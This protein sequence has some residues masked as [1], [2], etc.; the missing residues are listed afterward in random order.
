MFRHHIITNLGN[1]RLCKLYVSLGAYTNNE[2]CISNNW[3]SWSI[4]QA[5]EITRV[6]AAGPYLASRDALP[7]E[8]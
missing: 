4:A 5:Q 1:A 7:Q 6:M 2:T 3:D 8:K